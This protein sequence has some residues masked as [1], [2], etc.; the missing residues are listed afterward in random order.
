MVEVLEDIHAL[1]HLRD[2]SDLNCT[3]VVSVLQ[4]DNHQASVESRLYWCLRATEKENGVLTSCVLTSY[5]CAFM[6]FTDV[7]ANP[8][9]PSHVASK[10]LYVLQGVKGDASWF[11]HEDILLWCT[12]VGGAFSQPG[13]TRTEYAILLHQLALP[14]SWPEMEKL[15]RKFFWSTKL[16]ST[17]GKAFWD[18]CCLGLS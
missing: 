17:A 16:F 11:G 14:W 3:D 2:S 9:I 1:Q 13:P 10:L 15:L 5:L 7:W 4:I 8:F 18:A 12:V 6:L